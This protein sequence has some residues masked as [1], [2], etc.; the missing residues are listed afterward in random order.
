MN[1]LRE[2]LNSPDMDFLNTLYNITVVLSLSF[3]IQRD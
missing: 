3:I 2:A 1:D